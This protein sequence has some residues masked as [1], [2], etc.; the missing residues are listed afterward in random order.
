MWPQTIVKYNEK[1]RFV[2]EQPGWLV[3]ENEEAFI[4]VGKE[5]SFS[6]VPAKPSCGNDGDETVELAE[7]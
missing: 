1:F 3:Y 4:L 2:K 5:E 6:L 7:S